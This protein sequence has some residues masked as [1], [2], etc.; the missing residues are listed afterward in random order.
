[1]ETEPVE[2][3][4]ARDAGVGGVQGGVL[5]R[6]FEGKAPFPRNRFPETRFQVFLGKLVYYLR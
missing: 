5:G 3:G 4:S 6:R 2:G 1:V